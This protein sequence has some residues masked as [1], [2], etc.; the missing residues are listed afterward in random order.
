MSRREYVLSVE[1][2]KYLDCLILDDLPFARLIRETQ[3]RAGSRSLSLLPDEAEQLRGYFTLRLA[4]VGFDAD[5]RVTEEG[6]ILEGLID[7]LFCR[8]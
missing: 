6:R 5:Y 3:R 8:E 7:R 4:R 1:E 2:I